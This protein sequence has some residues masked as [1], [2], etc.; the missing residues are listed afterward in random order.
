MP[1]MPEVILPKQ[2]RHWCADQ[3]LKPHC[4]R[5]HDESNWFYLK[6]RG[7]HWRVNCHGHFQCGD[8]YAE[9]DRWALCDIEELAVPHSR[10]KFRDAVAAMLREKSAKMAA[11]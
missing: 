3:R 5:G 9:F 4:K 6:G 11:V 2:W 8:T 10:A 7:H 1:A